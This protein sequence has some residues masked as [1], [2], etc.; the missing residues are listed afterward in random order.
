[1]KLNNTPFRT[2]TRA[3]T[4]FDLVTLIYN[5]SPLAYDRMT[6]LIASLIKK[7]AKHLAQ[8]LDNQ[9]IHSIQ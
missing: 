3:K 1:M 6:I 7:N 8:Q 2:E 4:H 5:T 9:A